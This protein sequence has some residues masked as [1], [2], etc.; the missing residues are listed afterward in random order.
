V[1]KKSFLVMLLALLA[2]P[3]LFAQTALTSTTTSEVLD[4]REQD[5]DVASTSGVTIGDI[6]VVDAEAMEVLSIGTNP[7]R[8]RVIRGVEGTRASTHATSSDIFIDP[9]D[10]FLREDQVG[11]C[12]VA[13]TPYAPAI[14]LRTGRRFACLES[15]WKLVWDASGTVGETYATW[16]QG[17]A[18]ADA[19][20]TIFYIAVVPMRVTDIDVIW[21]VAES[22]GAMAV[23]VQKLTGTTEIGGSGVDLLSSTV[24]ATGTANTTAIGSTRSIPTIDIVG[25]NVGF[26]VRCPEKVYIFSE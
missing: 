22:T 12:T 8:I 21:D 16:A 6:A 1:I 15:L 20:S 23:Q 14:N 2:A 3:V 5:I 18:F 26:S 17:A 19:V 11:S 10:R 7:T 25:N 13:E 9:A 24:D 4:A